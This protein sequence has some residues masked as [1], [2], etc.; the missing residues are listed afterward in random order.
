MRSQ[1]YIVKIRKVV[2]R[3]YLGVGKTCACALAGAQRH[4]A[5]DSK[6]PRDKLSLILNHFSQAPLVFG[7]D[8]QSQNQS[9]WHIM[10]KHGCRNMTFDIVVY[11][12]STTL[13]DITEHR[14]DP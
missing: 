4:D 7:L 11:G 3:Q 9:V 5:P 13:P 6:H 12:I 2:K 8:A 14:A 1:P 10:C